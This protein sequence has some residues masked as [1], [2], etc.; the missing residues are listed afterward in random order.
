M[1]KTQK[2]P[3]RLDPDARFLLANERT[4]LAWIRTALA[5]LAGGIALIQLSGEDQVTQNVLGTAIVLLGGF[6]A[7]VGYIRFQAA[8]KAI[9]RGE[10]PTLGHEPFIQTGGVL[11][12]AFALVATHLAGIW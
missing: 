12:V 10:L 2:N 5:V 7:A 1:V 4:L 6:M 11:V 8:D 9:R 3:K